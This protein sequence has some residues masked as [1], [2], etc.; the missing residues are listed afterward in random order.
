[1]E[2]ETG[3]RLCDLLAEALHEM[4]FH[5][6]ESKEEQ[7]KIQE[8]AQQ[9]KVLSL[10]Y[11]AWEE[12]SFVQQISRQTVQQ[13]YHL[14]FLSHYVIQ[15]LKEHGI[16]AVLLKGSAAA[17]F[18]PVPELRK[19][20][21][22]DLLLKNE[23]Q[24]KAAW[25]CLKEQG[26]TKEKGQEACHHI[27]CVSPEHICVELHSS[28]VEPFDNARSNQILK[29]QQEEFFLHI[30]EEPLMGLKLPVLQKPYLA[31]HL[32][33]HMLQDFL[34]AGFGVRLLCDWVAFWEQGCSREEILTFLRL[35]R[36]SRVEGFAIAMTAVCVRYLGLAPESVWFWQTPIQEM[37]KEQTEALMDEIIEAQEFG[38]SD[39]SRMVT[40]RGNH[41]SDYI[42]EFHHQTMLTYKKAGRF[43]ILY[44]LLWICMFFGFLHRNRTLRG[45]SSVQV[46][47]NAGKRS[48]LVE[49]MK[50]FQ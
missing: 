32:L 46:L 18:Y 48:K 7:K 35:V 9:H 44:P 43:P 10:L 50:L 29:R 14:L 20:G 42:R 21:D 15:V 19:S 27:A 25:E 4:P 37:Q 5:I 26:F 41:L 1:M 49:K 22:V 39:H 31:Y 33:L 11:E 8:L 36:E 12:D 16:E 3:K 6:T 2:K 13:S 34:R 23:K 38:A 28:M 24:V 47:K 17:Q 40:L 45:V 30:K